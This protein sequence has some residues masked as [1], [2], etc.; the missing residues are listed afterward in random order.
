MPYLIQKQADGNTVKQW[1]IPAR[2]FSVGRGDQVDAQ[3]EDSEMSRQ[4][5]VITPQGNGY[6]LQDKNSTNGTL[7]LIPKPPRGER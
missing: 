7:E 2:P 6:V 4:H 5:F 3:I 1:D